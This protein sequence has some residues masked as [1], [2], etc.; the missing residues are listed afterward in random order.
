MART[1]GLE[2]KCPVCERTVGDHTMRQWDECMGKLT[3]NEPHQDIPLG[4]RFGLDKDTHFADSV[5]VKAAVLDTYS[6]P[7][8]TKIPVLVFEFATSEG[9]T[10]EPKFVAKV[11]YASSPEGLIQLVHLVD[12]SATRALEVLAEQDPP[13][14]ERPTGPGR[15]V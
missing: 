13:R 12:Q 5:W 10:P 6:G 15:R 8:R 2:D 11:A 9:S 1:E 7:L 4:A 3:R 14:R